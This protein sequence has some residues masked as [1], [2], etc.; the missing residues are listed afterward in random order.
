MPMS[1][2][3]TQYVPAGMLGP[4]SCGLVLACTLVVSP[5]RNTQL[6]PLSVPN[7]RPIK[8]VEGGPA[9]VSVISTSPVWETTKV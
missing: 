6:E 3:A 9:A 5:A 8:I 2:T 4:D 1:Y 7:P